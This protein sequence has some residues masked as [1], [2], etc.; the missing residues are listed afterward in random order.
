MME[1]KYVNDTEA[2]LK[3]IKAECKMNKSKPKFQV[4]IGQSHHHRLMEGTIKQVEFILNNLKAETK[5]FNE[6]AWVEKADSEV[7]VTVFGQYTGV[8]VCVD[9]NVERKE[10]EDEEE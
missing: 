7:E 6:Y 1:Y 9:I 2:A 5:L 4:R 10:D 3:R 8:L